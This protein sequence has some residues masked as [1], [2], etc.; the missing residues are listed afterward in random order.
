[1]KLPAA[2]LLAGGRGTRLGSLTDA[3]PKPLLEVAGRPF[4]FFVL[5]HLKDAGVER[6][7]ISTGYRAEQF[8]QTIG[9]RYRGMHVQ[10]EVE[11]EPLGTGGALMRSLAALGETA[12]VL[13]AD[14]LF[15]ISLA[16]MLRV[17]Q[18]MQADITFAVREVPDVSRYG[19][20]ILEGSRVISVAQ[21]RVP[22]PGLINGGIY[23]ISP[24]IF[25]DFAA[26]KRFSFETEFVPGALARLIV[27]GYTDAGYFIDMGVPVDFARAQRELRDP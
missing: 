3:V 19:A 8:D 17:H 16:R 11:D 20:V 10:Y 25:S 27:A 14:T 23:L 22:G 26:M 15:R 7:M 2:I 18:S 24:H 4:I 21:Q 1:M 6:I 12:F 5:D 13:N 9:N